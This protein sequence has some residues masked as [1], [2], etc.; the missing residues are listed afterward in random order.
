MAHGDGKSDGERSR[1]ADAA[2]VGVARGEH[3]HHEHEGDEQL[4]AEQ[5]CQRD[6]GARRRSTERVAC[7]PVRRETHEDPGSGHRS[8]GLHYDVQHRAAAANNHTI[9]ITSHHI[10]R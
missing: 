2:S 5:L 4:E 9:I 3:G 7:R 6:A 8:D 10:E 1:A